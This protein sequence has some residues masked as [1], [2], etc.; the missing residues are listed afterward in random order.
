MVFWAIAEQGSIILA[1]Y[2][3]ER[4]DLDDWFLGNYPAWFQS[5]NPLFVIGIAPIFAWLWVRLG[6]KQ[7]ST[8]KKFAFGLFFASMSF[9]VMIIPAYMNGTETL[10]SP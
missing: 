3:D 5:L 7:P 6:V 9:L 8:P 1:Q 2:A 4:T 10:V